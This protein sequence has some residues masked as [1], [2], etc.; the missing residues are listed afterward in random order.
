MTKPIDR[1]P[2]LSTAVL[3]V[4]PEPVFVKD[5]ALQF[6]WA[7]AAFEDLFNV[8]RGDIV[9]RSA[10]QVFPGRPLTRCEL[11]DRRVMETGKPEQVRETFLHN[12]RHARQILTRKSRLFLA[13]RYLM[14]GVMQDVT[15]QRGGTA[16]VIPLSGARQHA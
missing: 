10:A 4:L 12:S 13:G 11:T 6:V 5:E 8:A 14:V 1:W 7:N 15:A 3:D 16:P 2:G 9:G